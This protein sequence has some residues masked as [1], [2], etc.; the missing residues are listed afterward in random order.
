MKWLINLF[1]SSIG[2]KITMA[3]TG[4][5]LISFLLVHMSINALIFYNDGGEIFTIGAHFMATNIIIRTIE[6][7]LVL[8]FIIHIIQGLW[9]WKQNRDA[10]PVQYA[11]ATVTPNVTWYSRSMALL[12]TLLLLFLVVHTS[13]FWIPNRVNQFKFGEELPLYEMMIEKFQNPIEVVIY[14]FGCFTLFWHLFHGFKSALTSLGIS[15]PKW[16]PTL[17][18]LGNSFSIVV[19]LVLVMMPISIYFGWLK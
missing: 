14:V 9:I 13:N 4:L 17:A 5:F 15:H 2:K 11:Y 19:P 10:R 3:L 7:F 16:N 1:T 18:F 8:G 12:G 6:I